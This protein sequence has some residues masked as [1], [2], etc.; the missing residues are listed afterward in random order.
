MKNLRNLLTKI[1]QLTT[2]IETN[3]PELYRSLEENPL[4]IPATDHPHIDKQIMENYLES[5]KQ[6]LKHHLETHSTKNK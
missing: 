3:Y 5:L 2:N 6:L 1:T 4:T